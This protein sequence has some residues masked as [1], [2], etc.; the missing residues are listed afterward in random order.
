MT[1]FIFAIPIILLP[2]AYYFP[3]NI[4]VPGMNL[5]NLL[6]ILLVCGLFFSR[7]D[8][9]HLAVRGFLGAPLLGLFA[10]LLLGF[11]IAQW[12]DLSHV[13][14]DLVSLKN[15]IVYPPLYFIY[16]RCHLD[17]R[18]TRHLIVLVLV[19]SVIAGMQAVYQGIQFGFSAYSGLQRAVGPF[20]GLKQANRAG[21]YFA[22]FLPMLVAVA[23]QLR[24]RRLV[25]LAAIAGAVILVMAILFTYS[26]Q[27]YLI[28]LF[29]IM[30]L[31]LRRSLAAAVLAALLII[32]CASVLPPSVIDRIQ[33]TG[34][35]EAG[36]GAVELDTSTTSR[37]EIWKGAREM[38]RDHPMGVGLDRFPKYIGQYT[39][40]PR[41]DAHNAFVLILAE[42]GPLGLMA[43][44]W[45]FW[46][47]WLLARWLRRSA[48]TTR[49]E[50][51]TL[52]IGFTMTVVSM[53]LGNLYGSP[54]FQGLIMAN[55]W[56]L[57]GLMERYGM[58]KAH[59]A[60]IAHGIPAEPIPMFQRFPLVARALPGL[61]MIRKPRLP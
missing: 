10:V 57:C 31:M 47:M 17:L 48:G 37:F 11:V 43:M 21:V 33:E 3:V 50:A 18:G 34:Q 36:G 44:L 25:R 12:H 24:H 5:T 42:C 45:L 14:D 15:A 13:D 49:P 53:A 32:T 56:I 6:L 51:S 39:N 58:I 46:R 2:F 40:R 16:R 4:V 7:R 55:F 27:S 59:A 8:P 54:F 29:A 22:M 38:L 9:A 20:G 28:A 23:L 30:V 1:R 52:A 41:V 19:I 60:K 61:A 35:V 26:R